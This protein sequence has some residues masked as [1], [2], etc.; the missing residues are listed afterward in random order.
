MGCTMDE[1][2]WHL[3]ESYVETMSA[4]KFA[5]CTPGVGS[6]RATT[7]TASFA[8]HKGIMGRPVTD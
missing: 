8:R 2:D 4:C 5:V 7:H 6:H 3:S 1:I